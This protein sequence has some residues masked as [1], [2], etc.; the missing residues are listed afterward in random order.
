ML[1]FP[2]DPFSILDKIPFLKE[3]AF[4]R[5]ILDFSAGPLKK[6][7]YREIM[8]ALNRGISFPGVNRFNWKNGF[9][10]Q[11]SKPKS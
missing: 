2:Y 8:E 7:E 3:A 5:F 9:Y 1:V 4:N 11:K 10:V 6:A